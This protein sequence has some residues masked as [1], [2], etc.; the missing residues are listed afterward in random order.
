MGKLSRQSSGNLA[1]RY[2]AFLEHAFNPAN[3]RFRNF[4]GYERTWNEAQGS[5]D[6][7]GRALWALGTVLGRSKDHGLRGA[8]GRLF[9]IAVP[10]AL[11]F[12][13]PRAWAFT[14]LGI[15]EYLDSFPG[16]R[17]AQSMSSTLTSRLI[18]IHS[19]NQSS[20]WKWFEDV[21]AYANARLPQS[22]LIAGRRNSDPRAVNV[23]LDAL[24]LALQSSKMTRTTVISS[25]SDRRGF[26]DRAASKLALISNRLKRQVRSQP[27]SKPIA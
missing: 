16:D 7:H 22:V 21:L 15:Q 8:A 20:D 24:D 6:C 23:G 13:S 19:G 9:E 2:L 12:G 1:T 18:D 3:G 25:L 5:E 26:T 27:V 4:L 14:L 17:D 11:T 10:A